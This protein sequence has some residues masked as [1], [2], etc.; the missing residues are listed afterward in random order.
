MSL[1]QLATVHSS[2]RKKVSSSSPSSPFLFSPSILQREG[3]ACKLL[4]QRSGML[5]ISQWQK[6]HTTPRYNQ[7]KDDEDKKKG[8]DDEKE[9][10]LSMFKTAIG[11]FLVPVVLFTIFSDMG[12][13]NSNPDRQSSR[14]DG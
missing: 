3:R 6:L 14:P 10:M 4:A 5:D 1:R 8:D 13:S 12:A 2:Y 11:F 9:K 7:D